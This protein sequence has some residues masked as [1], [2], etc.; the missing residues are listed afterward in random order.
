[1]RAGYLFDPVFPSL[2]VF[3]FSAG[4]ATYLYRRTEHQRAEIRRAFGQYVSPDVVN[5]LAAHPDNLKLGGEV[6]D[7]TVLVCDIRN[8]TTISERL[9]AEELTAFINSFLTPLS[10]II[11]EH[12]GTIDKYMGDAIM[13]FW[14]AP[15][16]DPEHAQHGCAAAL[17]IVER[18]R[19]LND[20]WRAEAA[21]AGRSFDDVAIGIGL[22]S[23]ECCVGNLGSSRRFDYSAIGDT[24]NVSSR[25]ESLT[26]ALKVPL[27]V[28]EDTARQAGAL[29][30]I[31]I[32]LVRLKGRVTPSRVFTLLPDTAFNSDVHAALL[33]A[34]REARWEDAE[35]ILPRARES[36]PAALSQLYAVYAQRIARLKAT[37]PANWDGVYELEQK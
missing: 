25:L 9:N 29:P 33:A 22:N 20:G 30:F 16:D 28:G 7:L 35:G 17:H 4:S 37:N 19:A 10:D 8:F 18:M 1:M 27:L 32:D 12:G 11:M 34:Y 2:C 13:A 3:V 5:K 36:A 23:G 14:N 6:R 21:A 15:I 24:V 26:K 31:E